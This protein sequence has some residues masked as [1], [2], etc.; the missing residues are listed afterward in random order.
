MKQKETLFIR[1][2]L[3]WFLTMIVAIILSATLCSYADEKVQVVEIE[4]GLYLQEL[5]HV[6]SPVIKVME[7]TSSL[8]PSIQYVDEVD[9]QASLQETVK[10]EDYIN[11]FTCDPSNVKKITNLTLEDMTYLTEGTWWSGHEQTLY[12]LEQNYGINAGFAM[13]VSSL[14]SG[15]GTSS[16]ARNRN[17][18]Y[19]ITSSKNYGSRY[20]CTMYFGDLINRLYVDNGRVSVHTIGPKYCPPNRKWEIY[21]ESYMNNITYKVREKMANVM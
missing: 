8:T 10:K 17:N 14:E 19:G 21:M 7:G 12:D 1:N 2:T 20:N 18:F 11:N 3:F 6:E 4:K 13:A 16:R 15:H 9:A 5:T